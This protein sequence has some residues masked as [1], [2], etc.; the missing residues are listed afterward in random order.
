MGS[1]ASGS[2]TST[3]AVPQY[4]ED[5]SRYN[6][7][8]GADAANIGYVP[9]YGPDV[10]ALTPLQLAS[11]NNLSQNA[12]AFGMA[13]GNVT[14]GSGMPDPMQFAGG[15]NA[16]SS[17]PAFQEMVSNLQANN[18]DKYN[19]IENYFKGGSATG[20]SL[21]FGGGYNTGG[22][23]GSGGGY[24]TGGALGSGGNE[25]LKTIAAI[26][27]LGT[28]KSLLGGESKVGDAI[29]GGVKKLGGMAGFGGGAAAA[30]TANIANTA[31][32]L[33]TLNT[34]APNAINAGAQFAA[35]AGYGVSF[36]GGGAAANAANTAAFGGYGAAPPTYG[37]L[38]GLQ[39]TTGKLTSNLPA[40]FGTTTVT[41]AIPTPVT[42]AIPPSAIPPI[43]AP[44][45]ATGGLGTGGGTGMLGGLG[46]LPTM[47]QLTNTIMPMGAAVAAVKPFGDYIV[48]PFAR[49]VMGFGNE[50]DK[51]RE[52]LAEYSQ[53]SG[54]ND[55]KTEMS[56][57]FGDYSTYLDELRPP[58]NPFQANLSDI[59]EG[60]RSYAEEQISNLYNTPWGKAQMAQY[61]L[62]NPKHFNPDGS[63][64]NYIVGLNQRGAAA[65]DKYI[66]P[67]MD[68]N[69]YNLING[70]FRQ[71]RN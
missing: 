1:S 51:R 36:G 7:N 35:P 38:G 6:L 15:I 10:A 12:N 71:T 42:P 56:Q 67:T 66:K 26:A 20:G 54:L 61:Y 22:A 32:N 39:G 21:G 28:A 41:P 65:V 33:P 23:L 57:G 50:T 59:E 49:D 17:A 34:I 62:D 40:D 70:S 60:D 11:I 13:G 68:R 8:R 25:A 58:D 16:Y 48:K 64:S 29:V 2:E 31:L 18:P 9:K 43:P 27:G 44:S 63:K 4:L 5:A 30:N 69:K 19:Q 52:Q 37:S 14:G 3:T 55:Y 53:E 47:T 45:I 24:A 46:A